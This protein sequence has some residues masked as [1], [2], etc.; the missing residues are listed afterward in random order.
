MRHGFADAVNSCSDGTPFPVQSSVLDERALLSRV[1][2]KYRIPT[3]RSCR[4]LTRGDADVYRVKTATSDF[5]LK[6]YRPPRSLEETEGEAL[7]VL[8]LSAAGIPVVKPILRL[9]GRLA[10]QVSAPEGMRPMLLMEEA[11]P[12]LPSQLDEAL[13]TQIGEKVALVHCAADGFDTDFGIPAMHHDA[14]RREQVCHMGQ[15]LSRQDRTWLGEVSANLGRILGRLPRETPDFGLCHADLVM[16]N[17]RLTTEGMITLFDFANA[18]KT[19]RAYELA[20]VYGSLDHRYRDAGEHLWESFLRGYESVRPLP[21]ALS[22]HLGVMLVL[23]QISFL[24]GNCATLPLRLGTAPLESG[25]M[26]EGMKRLRELV[27]ESSILDLG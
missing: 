24:G 26:K 8:A 5:Y 22:E 16:S 25:F 23:R 3:P 12:P 2:K 20:I 21:E 11:P 9:D 18:L 14:L 15:F 1:V 7:F 6:V 10:S 19:W 4:F 13:L 27:E 17:L